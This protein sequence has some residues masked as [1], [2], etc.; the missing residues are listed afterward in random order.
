MT[1]YFVANPPPGVVRMGSHYCLTSILPDGRHQLVK[2]ARMAGATHILWFDTDMRFPKDTPQRLLA[3]NIPVVGANYPTRR[4]PYRWTAFRG[5]QQVFTKPDSTGLEEVDHLGF[6]VLLTDISVFEDHGPWFANGWQGEG[7]NLQVVGE[8]VF[9]FRHIK[10][11]GIKA[12]VDHDLSKQVG[13]VGEF[14]FDV[15]WM[16]AILESQDEHT[17]V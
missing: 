15:N 17:D 14:T 16:S 12:Y 6:G 7:E 2:Q 11:R 13:H 1:S 5:K 8:D 10:N 9:F 3:H 4:E